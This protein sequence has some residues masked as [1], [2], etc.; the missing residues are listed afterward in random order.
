MTTGTNSAKATSPN[1]GAVAKIENLKLAKSGPIYI[2]VQWSEW[3][4]KQGHYGIAFV[5]GEVE[6]PH[7]DPEQ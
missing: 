6:S 3:S 2:K 1:K 5:Q 7:P 4:S